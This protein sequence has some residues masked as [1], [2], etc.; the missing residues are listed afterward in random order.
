MAV[1]ATY[2]S[3]CALPLQHDHYVHAG[4]PMLKIYRGAAPDGGH[5]WE[6]HEHPFPFGPE[7][8]WLKDAVGLRLF[9]EVPEFIRGP[10]QDGALVDVQTGREHFV[11]EGDEE[12]RM[13]HA[14]CWERSGRPIKADAQPRSTGRHGYA[15]LASYQE[16]LFEFQ[17]LV[18]EGKSWALVDPSLGN[19]AG[20]RSRARIDALLLEARRGLLAPSRPHAVRT[21]AEVLARDSGWHASVLRTENGQRHQA[22]RYR[23]DVKPLLD[24][25]GYPALVWLMKEYAGDAL[26][27]PDAPT[28]Q[29]LEDFEVALKAAVE[30]D[31]AAILLMVMVGPG[32]VQFIAYARDELATRQRID[33][34]PGRDHPKPAEYD[35]EQ[36]PEW[37]VY[38][39]Q[40][41]QAR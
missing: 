4:D 36:D 5:L 31:D 20:L 32:Q 12:Y 22:L 18:D 37:K 23:A 41:S 13:L 19:E 9:G 10:L 25:S 39:E 29:A 6:A 26:G 17:E 21:V 11:G 15:L 27:R 35:N 40:V 38:F 1:F 28:R 2:C 14:A 24:V 33:V 34:L 8:A 7:H 16:Q 3:L 30:A